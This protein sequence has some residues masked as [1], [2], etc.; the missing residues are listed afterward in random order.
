MTLGW[1]FGAVSLAALC[2]FLWLNRKGFVGVQAA[3]IALWG[4]FVVAG[5]LALLEWTAPAEA[6]WG[7]RIGLAI[8]IALASTLFMLAL[9]NARRR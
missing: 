7:I 6:P 5:T 2:G 8:A 4:T 1:L 9:G 3:S